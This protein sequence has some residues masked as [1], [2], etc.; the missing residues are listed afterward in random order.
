MAVGSLLAKFAKKGLTLEGSGSRLAAAAA[1]ILT[2]GS[3]ATSP[4]E[5]LP[6]HARGPDAGP[7]DIN[8][9]LPHL[10]A[11]VREFVASMPQDN[12]PFLKQPIDHYVA[13]LNVVRAQVDREFPGRTILIDRSKN[14]D[15]EIERVSRVL[16]IP[17]QGLPIPAFYGDGGP[18]TF[19]ANEKGQA[20]LVFGG[21]A[22]MSADMLLQRGLVRGNL[23]DI[24]DQQAHLAVLWHEVGHAILGPS[25]WKA[26]AFAALK[27]LLETGDVKQVE[28]Y[29]AQRELDEW[30]SPPREPHLISVALREILDRFTAGDYGPVG[31][32]HSLKAIAELVNQ[33]P[34]ADF[35]RFREVRD[36]FAKAKIDPMRPYFVPVK[37]GMVSTDLVSWM[38]S[39]PQVPE[40]KRIIDLVDYVQADPRTR[41]L[42][43]QFVANPD[44]TKLELER[45]ADA[46]DPI[47]RKLSGAFGA[48]PI[49]SNEPV[50]VGDGLESAADVKGK[51]IE[52]DRS[53]AVVKF[54]LDVKEFTV[55][56]GRT[57]R[58]VLVGDGNAGVLKTYPAYRTSVSFAGPRL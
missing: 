39:A 8:K 29:A 7:P 23:G 35:S 32:S 28:F 5:A 33:L 19:P 43:P 18:A 13:L 38:R 11:P 49:S 37:E 45:L 12:R 15:A 6:R 25:E 54:D 55:R 57:K 31:H 47:A 20:F 48:K 17:P 9:I 44:K 53:S 40:F 2:V 26:D 14:P 41:K 27:I 24:D 16:H 50:L 36:A 30:F 58:P 4:A 51:L 56:D 22:R 52:F 34:E 21:D 3:L 1:A 10:A 42:P 46:G